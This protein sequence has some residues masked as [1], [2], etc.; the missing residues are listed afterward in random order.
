M[1]TVKNRSVF[2]VFEGWGSP[3]G[4][5]IG[6]KIDVDVFVAP[7]RNTLDFCSSTVAIKSALFGNK[8]IRAEGFLSP[9]ARQGDLS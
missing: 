4:G 5:N 6:L 9:G 8:G 3:G 2:E 1:K 7:F